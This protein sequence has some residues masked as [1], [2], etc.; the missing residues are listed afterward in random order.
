M[1]VCVYSTLH[2]TLLL[3]TESVYVCVCVY[4]CQLSRWCRLWTWPVLPRLGAFHLLPLLTLIQSWQWVTLCDP[5]DPSV[6]W[7]MTRDPWPSPRP[8]HESIRTTH[9]SWWVHDYCRLRDWVLLSKYV[10]K[11]PLLILIACQAPAGPTLEEKTML[12]QFLH[13]YTSPNRGSSVYGTDPWPIWPMTHWPI[14][15]SAL[16]C[17]LFSLTML[18][19]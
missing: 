11:L 19:G 8:R 1:C 2:Q 15:C 6:S 7:P 14:V 17:W 3:I 4:S 16:I 10:T 9:E 18:N 13:V 5:C 12:N